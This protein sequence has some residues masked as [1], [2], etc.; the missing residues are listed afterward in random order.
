VWLMS[1]FCSWFHGNISRAE[2]EARL[3][4]AKEGSFLVRMCEKNKEEYALSLKC[5]LTSLHNFVGFIENN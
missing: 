2:A 4:R 1:C 5:V 3:Q